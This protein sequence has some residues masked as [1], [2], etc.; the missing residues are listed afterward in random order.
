MF[1]AQQ[2]RAQGKAQG[3]AQGKAQGRAQGWAQGRARGR[4]QGR[5]YC[6]T[7]DH[8]LYHYVQERQ[9]LQHK[10]LQV[11]AHY[12]N[13][14]A[15]L[16]QHILCCPLQHFVAASRANTLSEPP[17]TSAKPHPP[18]LPPPAPLG[19]HRSRA[20]KD[21]AAVQQRNGCR[22]QYLG[23]TEGPKVSCSF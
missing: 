16:L 21:T 2:G 10:Q 9:A 4:A 23:L 6:I 17:R 18:H 12:R 1:S 7:L 11:K 22:S 20:A 19:F 15:S 3:R 5:A 14:H 8:S 13:S